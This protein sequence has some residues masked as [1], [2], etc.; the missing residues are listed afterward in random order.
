M[1]TVGM[2]E[3]G[4]GSWAGPLTV[5]AVSLSKPINGLRDS[6]LLSKQQREKL[7]ATIYEEAVAWSIGWSHQFEID[8]MGLS[9]SLQRAYNRAILALPCLFDEIIIDGNVN[10]LRHLKKVRLVIGADRSVP[11]VSAASIIAKVARDKYM[12]SQSTVYPGYGFERHVGYGTRDH[13]L[14]LN[15]YG[16]CALHRQSFKPVKTYAPKFIAE[17]TSK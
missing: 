17:D 16:V 11:C 12:H 4:R 7:A 13:C 9:V 8:S 1:I 5:A 3:V 6:K 10:F 14:S 15:S 2:D